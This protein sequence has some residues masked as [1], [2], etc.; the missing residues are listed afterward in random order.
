MF[1]DDKDYKLHLRIE[2]LSYL[3]IFVGALLVLSCQGRQSTV[4]DFELYIDRAVEVW[5]FQGSYLVARGDNILARGSRGYADLADQRTNSPETKY[6]IG[7][8]T[9][10]FTAIAILQLVERG[11]VDLD[12][13]ISEYIDYYPSARNSAITV[14]DLLCH[15]SGIPDLLRNPKFVQRIRD[16][17][18][19]Q[20][21]VSCFHDEPLAFEPG[22]QYA[23]SSS[24]YV[25][26]GLIIEA[27]SGLTWEEYVDNRICVPV[28]ME[29]TGVYNDYPLRSDFA[30]GYY[31]DQ[32][33]SLTA[34]P[35]VHPSLGYSAG[36]LAST[37]DDLFGLN[38]ALYDTTL[39]TLHSLE[40]M[41]TAYSPTYGYG[42][43]VD[44][45]GGHKFTAH[46]G[47]TPGYVSIIQRWID[48]SVCVIV[49]SN[50]VS[51]SAHTIANALAG[52]ALHESC[53]MPQN[54]Q[55]IP[56]TSDDL[57]LFEGEYKLDSGDLRRVCLRDGQLVV[58]H[59]TGPAR[60]V[61]RE[62]GD[63]FYFAHD[64]MTTIMFV[65]DPAGVVVAHVLNQAFDQDTAWRAESNIGSPD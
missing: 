16:S 37:V 13:E 25:L 14:H 9:K 49:L 64:Q 35:P 54:K 40:T 18:S 55:P 47:G 53:D 41:F 30:K 8:M 1:I 62:Q 45:F 56:I 65:R 21:M 39:L 4:T 10:P 12:Q 28:G 43:F 15:R 2:N 52:I 58:Q 20:E 50:D 19:P 46:R 51:V 32:S 60:L 24:N 3:L 42:W 48:D 27:V 36:A 6:L 5:G 31:T 23:Y 26:L 22:S 17:I 11:L 59:S 63:E 33:G 61:L 44:D 7:S 38:T 57:A 29:N 34:V